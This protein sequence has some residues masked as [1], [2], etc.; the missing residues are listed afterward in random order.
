MP[1][2]PTNTTL[3]HIN[4]VLPF[5]K[6]VTVKKQADILGVEANPSDIANKM[7]DTHI[8]AVLVCIQSGKE[9]PLVKAE[10]DS[11]VTVMSLV[12]PTYWGCNVTFPLSWPR[13]AVLNTLKTLK[14]TQRK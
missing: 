6:P 8:E 1:Q 3:Y 10:D 11:L 7:L 4:H 13:S 9:A 14:L 5:Q 2:A 12:D